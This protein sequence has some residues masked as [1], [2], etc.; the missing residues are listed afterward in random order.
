MLV[1]QGDPGTEMYILVSGEVRV[2]V[3]SN[4]GEEQRE[5]ARRHSGDYVGEMSILSHEPRSAS[6]VAEGTVRALCIHQKQ[7]E[8]ILRE[9]PE[10]SLA[11]MRILCQRLKEASEKVSAST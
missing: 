1:R 7:F 8:G 4:G 10:T 9:R 5:I 11:L 2:L 6:L 3:T